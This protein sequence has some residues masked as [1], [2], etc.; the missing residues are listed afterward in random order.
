M[1]INSLGWRTRGAAAATATNWMGAF[2]VTQFTKVSPWVR[3]YPTATLTFAVQVGVD[4]L[5]WQFYLM[6]CIFCYA[7]FPIVYAFYPET[8]KRTLEDMDEIFRSNPGSFVFRDKDLVRRARP[9]KFVD[10]E[11]LRAQHASGQ[12]MEGKGGIVHVEQEQRA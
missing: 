7:Y 4:S 12:A 2:I 3:S 1:Q 11:V 5:G 10:A 9:Q 6:F 8:C